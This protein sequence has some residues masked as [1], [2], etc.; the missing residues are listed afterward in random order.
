M[1]MITSQGL[2]LLNA[3]FQGKNLKDFLDRTPL[4]ASSKDLEGFKDVVSRQMWAALAQAGLLL[5]APGCYFWG[6]V[7]DSL[8][9]GDFVWILLPS[10]IVILVARSFR[11]I[12]LRAWSL[13]SADQE[14]ASERDR[15]VSI[16]KTK[17]F[18]NW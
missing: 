1:G 13:P 18:P 15:I 4:L 9:P 6:L 16:W 8:K 17:P 5:V 12:E 14:I 3:I 10:V 7:T 11:G 2:A